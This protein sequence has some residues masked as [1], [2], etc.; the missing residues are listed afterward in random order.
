MQ[1]FAFGINHT[2]APLSLRE[3][4]VFNAEN[5]V[6]ALRDLVERHPVKEA[7]I[8]STCNRT[9]VYCHTEEPWQAMHWLADYHKLKSQNLEPHLYKLPQERAVKHAFRVASGLDSMVLGEPQILGQFK[10][11]VRTAEPAGTLG[12][13]LNKLFPAHVLGRQ[14][15][16]LRNRHRRE[17]GVDGLRRGAACRAHLSEHRR[18]ERAVHRRG[19]NDRA[20]P[21]RISPR[22]IR[23]T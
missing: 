17:H 18:T 6:Q 13:L 9:E 7:A 8:I 23:A 1:L 2:T 15:R 5:M 22:G 19:R 3:Q 16:A 4:V 12:L 14:G 21:P 11:A 10:D 20:V